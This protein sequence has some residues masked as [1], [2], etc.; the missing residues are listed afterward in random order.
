MTSIQLEIWTLGNKADHLR[1]IIFSPGATVIVLTLSTNSTEFLQTKGDLTI[2]GL[3]KSLLCDARFSC[4][5]LTWEMMTLAVCAG[6]WAFIATEADGVLE[7]D[8]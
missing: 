8:G 6:L 2:N 7:P 3:S 5:E 4:E 1:L